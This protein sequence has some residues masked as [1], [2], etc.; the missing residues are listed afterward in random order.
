[1][2]KLPFWADD[3]RC[4]SHALAEKVLGNQKATDT[5]SAV[6]ASQ[7]LRDKIKNPPQA[8]RILIVGKPSSGKTY[9]VEQASWLLQL[10]TAYGNAALLSGPGYKGADASNVLKALI[11]DAG[12]G[13]KTRAEAS[14]IIVL[15][16]ICK[17]VRRRDQE[18]AQTI[19]YSL[20]PILNSETVLIEGS[21]Y[22]EPSIHFST[23]NT[24]VFCM[25]VFP[26]TKPSDW[27]DAEKSRNTLVKS[28]FTEE[29]ASRF[30]HFIYL[31]PITKEHLKKLVVSEGDS[32]SQL[33]Q[34]GAEQPRLTSSE[35]NR[36]VTKVAGSRF[37]FRTA[38][39][40]IHSLLAK[41]ADTDMRQ[42]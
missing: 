13:G 40:E 1:M 42:F 11:E 25:G 10:P 8:A 3:Y 5:I 26:D 9:L 29:F 12:L 7:A 4:Y 19:Q 34:T 35:V 23:K 28:G 31:N 20:L 27:S 38:R 24:L 17:I 30:T 33:Y 32:L 2:K 41:K 21:G 16:E 14:S 37:G 6:L 22:D 36:V 39:A 15:D 18:Y